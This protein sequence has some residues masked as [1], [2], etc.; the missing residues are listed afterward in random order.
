[1][2]FLFENKRQVWLLVILIIL[3]WLVF[4]FLFKAF[5]SW[6][7]WI[8][9]DLKTFADYGPVGD[10]YGSLNTLFTSA[11]LIIVMYSAYLQ[12]QANKD[13]REAM[14]EQLKQAKEATA[15]QLAQA[16]ESTNLQLSQAK[17]SIEEQLSLA[18]K[19]HDAQINETKLAFF[20]S[21]FYA[22]LN[23]RNEKLK[24]LYVKN[25]DKEFT[26]ID[27]FRLFHLEFV[28]LL[29]NEWKG[30]KL[31]N[32]NPPMIRAKFHLI[33]KELNSGDN[34]Y[35][36]LDYFQIYVSLFTL[37]KSSNLKKK[38]QKFFL[39]V[40]SN[41]MNL[42]EQVVLFFI[43]PFRTTLLSSLENTKVFNSF[44]HKNFEKFGL[45][46]HKS[47]HFSLNKWSETF[48]NENK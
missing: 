12:R 5:M 9:A 17:K 37:I 41:S 15:E 11:T 24:L 19:T 44:H 33:S 22:L 40:I 13:A 18:K 42:S 34:F 45:K 2:G 39:K 38:D 6:M 27:V 1:M 47:S 35:P 28:K 4:P 3:I 7:S 30:D 25:N 10:I 23:L 14:A 29:K 8:G 36:L 21:Q 48:A 16:K 31:E 46:F 32:L 20:T 26:G 43:A